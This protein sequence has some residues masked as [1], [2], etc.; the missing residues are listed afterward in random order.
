M[1]RANVRSATIFLGDLSV[2]CTERDIFDLFHRFGSVESVQIKKGEDG[3]T[4][5]PHLCYGFVKFHHRECAEMAYSALNGKVFLGRP[6]RIGWAASN[7]T[8]RHQPP[9]LPEKKKPTAQVHVTFFCP[10]SVAPVTESKLREIFERFGN[11]VDVTINRADN[12]M[13]IAIHSGFGFIHYDLDPTGVQSALNAIEM[14]HEKTIDGISFG[15]TISH[16]LE[17]YLKNAAFHQPTTALNEQQAPRGNMNPLLPPTPAGSLKFRNPSW[18]SASMSP[19]QSSSSRSSF[20]STPPGFPGSGRSFDSN[21]HDLSNSSRS[22]PFPVMHDLPPT[23]LAPAS[24]TAAFFNEKDSSS[25]FSLIPNP[26]GS[27]LQTDFPP[28]YDHHFE[29]YYPSASH[30]YYNSNPINP[31]PFTD[32]NLYHSKKHG[33]I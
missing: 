24:S 1:S 28:S 31:Y 20:T 30:K 23:R 6:L 16:G 22:M 9:L 8:S 32:H 2:Y 26:A 17:T 29:T 14:I 33:K 3:T 11:V 19:S 25:S 13:E 5:K 27:Q 18:S 4:P 15:C 7:S 21:S 10:L 12:H